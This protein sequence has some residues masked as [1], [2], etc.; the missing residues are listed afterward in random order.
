MFVWQTAGVRHSCFIARFQ[1]LRVAVNVPLPSQ[2]RLEFG[3]EDRHVI[4]GVET[5]AHLVAVYLDDHHA[6]VVADVDAFVFLPCQ[7]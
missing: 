4:R 2:P 5:Q 1:P 7:D 6:D 3:T